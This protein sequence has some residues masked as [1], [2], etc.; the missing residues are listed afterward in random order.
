MGYR[1]K[2]YISSLLPLFVILIIQNIS[3][4]NF[5]RAFGTIEKNITKVS[6]TRDPV[7]VFLVLKDS[8]Q[9]SLVF[10]VCLL[11][12]FF[13]STI[14]TCQLYNL[15]VGESDSKSL[16]KYRKEIFFDKFKTEGVQI[17]TVDIL[18]YMF[19]YLFPL[20][21]LNVN[22]Y[23]SI[24]SNILLIIFIGNIYD[25]NNNSSINI[26]FLLKNINVYQIN[27]RYQIITNLTMVDIMENK[28]NTLDVQYKVL[29]LTERTFIVKK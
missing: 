8:F 6:E 24:F 20:L 3:I 4:Q 27:A 29:E 12:A 18:N 1:W 25:K 21:S 14:L 13:L 7:K 2:L 19:T 16:K 9:P 17:E 10:W 28:N 11:S 15:V 23:G 26:I 5:L 22:S